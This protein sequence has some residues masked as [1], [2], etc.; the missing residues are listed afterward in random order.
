M[1]ARVLYEKGIVEYVEAA[2]K[3]KPQFPQVRFQLLG[4]FDEAGNVGIK[5]TLFQEW[6]KGGEIEHLGTSVDVAAVIAQ[7][8]CVVLPSY[9]EVT[10]KSLLEAAAM[11]K[12]IITTNVPGCKETVVNNQNGYLCEVKNAG[13]LAAKMKQLLQLPDEALNQMGQASRQLALSRF[14]EKI[15]INQYLKAINSVTGNI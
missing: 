15:V 5:K 10:P 14:D 2:K 13:D 4:A 1:I 7:A 6:I 12:P 9:R 11:G 8:D 3:L